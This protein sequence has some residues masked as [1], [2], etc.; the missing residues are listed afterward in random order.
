MT[1]DAVVREWIC[2][3]GV[4][5]RERTRSG[6]PPVAHRCRLD[7]ADR[8]F[9]LPHP[10]V[11]LITTMFPYDKLHVDEQNPR[12]R[13]LDDAATVELALTIGRR[14]LLNPLRVTP[15]GG[16]L[17]GQRRYLAI[18]CLLQW[19][20]DGSIGHVLERVDGHLEALATFDARAA[21]FRREGVPCIVDDRVDPAIDALVDNLHRSDMLSFDVAEA[22]VARLDRKPTPAA[23]RPTLTALAAE[24]GKSLAWVSRMVTAYRRACPELR[25]VW[26]AD[27]I[28]FERV[29]ALADLEHDAQR[30]ALAGQQTPG[31]HGRPGID[32][33][34]ALRDKLRK[35]AGGAGDRGRLE[36]EDYRR[37]VLAALEWVAGEQPDQVLERLLSA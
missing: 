37:G 23:P 34:K 6:P 32:K 22:L 7:P 14:G 19:C 35:D 1:F 3:C 4:R 2:P 24:V 29:K 8:P 21:A 26:A 16:I 28:P 15:A 18:G 33:V 5:E 27:R 30:E 11:A 10:E 20:E 13:G 31:G 25:E 17:A 36:S 9:P 12:R